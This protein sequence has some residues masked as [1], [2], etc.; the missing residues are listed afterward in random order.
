MNRL[1]EQQI[2]VHLHNLPGWSHENGALTKTFSFPTF[3]SAIAFVNAVAE[4]AENA[5]HHP[6]LTVRYNR[7]Q[8]TLTT[9][10]SGGVTG[11]DVLLAQQIEAL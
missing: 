8:V 10:D 5:N 4:A 9:H 6:D 11:K 7:V 2:A 3:V 1:N